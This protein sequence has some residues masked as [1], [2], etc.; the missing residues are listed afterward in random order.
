MLKPRI[1]VTGATG[2]TGSLVVA[3]L[4]KAGYLL[5]ALVHREDVRSSAPTI[6]R[7][8]IARRYA[9]LPHNRPTLGNWLRQVAQFVMAPL[10]TGFNLDRYD[11]ELRSPFP[12]DR[13]LHLSQ[14][15]GWASTPWLTRS[16]AP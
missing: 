3:D 10:S 15:S 11:R 9:A 16:D 7:L 5:R 13:S 12:S 4:L 2:K 1:L 6:V 8:S 14:T